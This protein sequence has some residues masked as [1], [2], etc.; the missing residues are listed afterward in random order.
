MGMTRRGLFR[1]LLGLGAATALAPVA[2]FFPAMVMKYRQTGI[3]TLAYDESNAGNISLEMLQTAYAPTLVF[4]P[5]VYSM[6]VRC[7]IAPPVLHI[8]EGDTDV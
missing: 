4:K 5:K 3:S 6:S 7:N 1:G 8:T 2:K